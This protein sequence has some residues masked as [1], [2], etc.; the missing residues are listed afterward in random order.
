M[1]H[2][3]NLDLAKRAAA[4]GINL[5]L[6]RLAVIDSVTATPFSN[7]VTA[8]EVLSA[9]AST[10]KTYDKFSFVAHPGDFQRVITSDGLDQ[11]ANIRGAKNYMTAMASGEKFFMENCDMFM[12]FEKG[13]T[14]WRCWT[15]RKR[16]QADPGLISRQLGIDASPLMDELVEWTLK[17]LL[18]QSR[19]PG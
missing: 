3:N 13:A 2:Q 10:R 12:I 5:A 7:R 15:K 11:E 17:G 18:E 19:K 6:L 16:I 8:P 9:L 14:T 1:S 4:S